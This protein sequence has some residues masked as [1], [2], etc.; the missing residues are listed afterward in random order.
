M[1]KK[2]IQRVISLVLALV[3]VASSAIIPAFAADDAASTTPGTGINSSVTD[4]TIDDIKEILDSVTYAEYFEKYSAKVDGSSE[5]EWTVAIG[6]A[7]IIIDAVADLYEE[8]TDAEWTVFDNGDAILTPADGTVAWVVNIPKTA[9]YSVV[10]EYFPVH[11]DEDGNVISKATDIERIFRINSAVPFLEARYLTLPKT[12]TNNYVKAEYKLGKGE[13]AADFEAK[14]NEYNLV[15]EVEEREGATYIIYEIPEVWTQKAYEYL[16]EELKVRFFTSDIDRNEIRPNIIQSPSWATYEIH[17]ANGYYSESFEFVFEASEQTVISLT[18]VNEPMAIKSIQLVPHESYKTYEEASKYYASKE[19]GKSVVKIEAEYVSA[20]TSQ[21]I[22]PVE[23][24]RSAINSPNKAEYSMLNSIGGIGGDKWQT[25][26]QKLT[27]KMAV[28]D[29]GVYNIVARFSQST[30]DGMF[31]SRQLEIY[32]NYTEEEYLAKFG[33]LEGY[34]NGIPFAEAA[35]LRFD[36][37]S[38]WQTKFLASDDDTAL[39]FYFREG[40]EY[41]LV[42][43]VTLGSMGD[44]VSQVESILEKINSNYLAILKLTGAEP[45]EYRDYG[46]VR[47]LPDV[48]EDLGESSEALYEIAEMLKNMA[49]V[50][51]SMVATLEQVAWLLDRMYD[52]PEAEIAKNLTQL[53]SYIGSLGTWLSDAKTQPL[54]L[55]YLQIQGKG[56]KLPRA[57]ANFFQSLIY[58]I[59]CFFQSFFRNYD[60]MGAMEEINEDAEGIVE[61][62]LATGR[63]QTQV[64]RSLINSEFTPDYKYTVNL[65]LVSGGTLL[66]SILSKRGPDVYIGLG[67][68][69]VINYAIRGALMPIEKLEGFDEMVTNPETR[70]FNEAAMIVLTLADAAGVDHT[71]GLPEQQSFSM[72]FVRKDILAEL[73]LD[74]PKTWDDVLSMVPVLQ[75]NNMQIGMPNDYKIFLYQ[76][77][78]DLFAD[79]GMRINLD[80]NTALESFE[81]MCNLFT[82]YSFPY[83]Y[84]FANRF[85]TGEMPIGFAGYTGTYNQLKVFATEIEGLWGMYP[86]P[87]IED[88]NGKINN[89]AVSGCSA[90]V[91]VTGCDNV[92]GA[93]AFMRWHSGTSFQQQ[94]SN[95]M[96]SI[97]GPSAKH[98]TANIQAL[99]SLPWTTDELKEIKLQFNNLASIPNYPGHYIIGRY[100]NFAFLDAFNDKADPANSLLQHINAINKEITRKRAEFDLETLDYNGI[101]YAR[102]SLKRLA[103]ATTL[104]ETGALTIQKGEYDTDKSGNK[105][106]VMKD[107]KYTI[108]S[109]LKEK[110]SAVFTDVLDDFTRISED[111]KLSYED[112][113]EIVTEAIA[114]M[115]AISAESN[116]SSADKAGLAEALKLMNDAVKAL[117][118]YKE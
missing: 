6:E 108:S 101:S 11:K 96:V 50:K 18:G 4:A 3:C 30:L 15:A 8:G 34:Y 104:L 36:Y 75:A 78:G 80:S 41:S 24:T 38:K 39:E 12:Y 87:G 74:I 10:I 94:Y 110:H 73:G 118:S 67:D 51:G 54:Q 19:A 40:V 70:Q 29:S 23:D 21:T 25:S 114:A 1:N 52:D 56:G 22:Y 53:K 98:P 66:P 107:Y 83:Q 9:R 2:K 95:E 86:M 31:S 32:T 115:E 81:M 117:E 33:N 58:E 42:L 113:I 69:D 45:D 105:I 103:Q 59:K 88:E 106:V 16:C 63:D 100:T 47:V 92:D 27:Y 68:D 60:R 62:W 61:V 65:K 64:T 26:G 84:D 111:K 71:Y 99:E 85:R 102:L 77:G 7:P 28:D 14:A 91:M 49:G 35:K 109:G 5:R 37:S 79:D 112:Q 97:M 43:G 57:E 46:F 44:V 93:W 13:K 116:L 48:V 72:M 55:D 82:M 76:M 17:D 90:I 20:T 89:V